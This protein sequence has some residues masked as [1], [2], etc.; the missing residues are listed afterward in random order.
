MLHMRIVDTNALAP[1]L[2]PQGQLRLVMDPDAAALTVGLAERLAGAFAK[3]S[4]AGLLQLGAAEVGS[5]LPPALAW[6][7]DWAARYVTALCATPEGAPIDVAVPDTAALDRLVTDAPPM[8]GAEYLSAERLA[9]LWQALDATLRSELAASGLALGQYLA[10]RHAAWHQ[11]GRVHFNLAENRK[12]P[13]APFAFLATYT[14][15]LS[16]QG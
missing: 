12:D 2:S 9:A 11:V 5:V 15:R 1:T 10:T 4:G 13:Q 14:T 7:R 8:T 3:G 16:A 6:W